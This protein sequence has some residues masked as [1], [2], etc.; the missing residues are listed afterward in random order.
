M[1]FSL[2]RYGTLENTLLLRAYTQNW[3]ALNDRK[4]NPWEIIELESTNNGT[5][6]TI[7]GPIMDV[8]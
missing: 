5:M 2:A 8:M 7:S 6:S 3:S 4:V 1:Y